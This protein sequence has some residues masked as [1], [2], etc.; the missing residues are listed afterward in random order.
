MTQHSQHSADERDL[1]LLQHAYKSVLQVMHHQLAVGLSLRNLE[2]ARIVSK[3]GDE[4]CMITRP[5]LIAA[6]R[7]LAFDHLIVMKSHRD[8]ESDKIRITRHGLALL[9]NGVP[10][11]LPIAWHADVLEGFKRG[12]DR[13]TLG[14]PGSALAG[15]LG[16]ALH[17]GAQK[18]HAEYGVHQPQVSAL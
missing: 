2:D 14:E 10:D 7:Q 13:H 4:P 1:A 6:I 5:Y 9:K 8:G 3:S 12:D 15:A 17:I 11:K 16:E 18:H